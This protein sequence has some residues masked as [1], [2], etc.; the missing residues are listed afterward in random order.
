MIYYIAVSR[1][2]ARNYE[3]FRDSFP[4]GKGEG[5]VMFVMTYKM[6]EEKHEKNRRTARIIAAIAVTLAG[7]IVA[8]LATDTSSAWY[9]SL[10]LSPLQ[11]PP[12]AFAAVWT[13]LYVLIAVSFALV[14]SKRRVCGAAVVGYVVNLVLNALWSP[15]F[16]LAYMP[17][18][19]LVVM[20]AL[21]VNLVILM[22][23]VSAVS[24]PAFYMLVP[25]IVWLGIATILNVSVIVLN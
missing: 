21:I 11:P 5:R 9:E 25:Y 8:S 16:F 18:P 3:R 24:R 7:A 6:E 22:R 1:Y 10:T 19:A 4:G 13:V 12:W 23:N 2:I 17:G 14:V 15:V 20:I